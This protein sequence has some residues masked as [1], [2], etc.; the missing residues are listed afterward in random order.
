MYQSKYTLKIPSLTDN[1]SSILVAG[2][3]RIIDTNESISNIKDIIDIC[4][5]Y[6][7]VNDKITIDDIINGKQNS[8][9]SS[10]IFEIFKCQWSINLFFRSASIWNCECNQINES[11]HWYCNKCGAEYDPILY[12]MVET[13]IISVGLEL[14]SLP[15][16]LQIIG[17]TT[18]I[19]YHVFDAENI[20]TNT[21]HKRQKW[22]F[23]M[24]NS[25]QRYFNLIISTKDIEKA[26]KFQ[27]D[28]AFSLGFPA[29]DS[30]NCSYLMQY[31]IMKS[32]N[33]KSMT[34][35][36]QQFDFMQKELKQIKNKFIGHSAS[37]TSKTSIK[38][39]E[40]AEYNEYNEIYKWLTNQCG[41]KGNDYNELFIEN[42]VEDLET[43][44]LLK[45]DDLKSMGIHKIG[46]RLKIMHQIEKLLEA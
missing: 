9:L 29:T 19:T 10:N 17:A 5:D 2:Y 42:G 25:I 33:D 15:D 8:V 35:L 20:E 26:Q 12:Q 30:D 41:F 38:C 24:N 27:L 40:N 32:I 21:I 39:G 37:I 6:F 36:L 7:C 34:K 28:A 44:K 18:D 43:V 16:P 46:H 31:N 3:I 45:I 4:D 11:H 23:T 14:V 1:E 13:N 22:N